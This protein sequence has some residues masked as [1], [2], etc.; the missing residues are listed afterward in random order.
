MHDRTTPEPGTVDPF[1]AT[2]AALGLTPAAAPTRRRAPTPAASPVP[3]TVSALGDILGTF[4]ISAGRATVDDVVTSFFADRGLDVT[5][6]SFRYGRLV[7]AAAPADVR[8]ARFD[9][10]DLA[11]TLDADTPG[12]VNAVVVVARRNT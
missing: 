4:G 3:S 6:A 1:A 12:E 8:P 9:L 11:A 5:V 7:L 10:D 2:L